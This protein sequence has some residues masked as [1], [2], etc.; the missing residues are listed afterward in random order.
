MLILGIF[1]LL[2]SLS[3]NNRKDLSILYSRTSLFIIFSC[4][5]ILISNTLILNKNISTFNGLI[6]TNT[7]IHIFKLFIL[8]ISNVILL[9]TSFFPRR[10]NNNVKENIYE[11]FFINKMSE[12]FRILEY[13]LIILLTLTGVIL[14]LSNNDLVTLFLSIELQSY[15]LYLLCTIYK[16]S[17]LSTSAGLTYFLLGALAS[18]FILLGIALIY[19]NEGNLTLDNIYIIS[20]LSRDTLDN[21]RMHQYYKPFYIDMSLLILSIGLLFKISAAPFHF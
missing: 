6:Y 8:I 9:L 10:T 7:L 2:L 5:T 21:I 16:N 19:S 20:N 12:Q 4:I 13:C 3:T 17:E 15:G 1:K 18:C 14:L 11:S